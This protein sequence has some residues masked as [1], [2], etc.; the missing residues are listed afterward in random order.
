MSITEEEITAWGP[1]DYVPIDVRPEW[2]MVDIGPGRYP[3]PRADQYVDC[4]IA[5][6]ERLLEAGKNAMFSDLDEG[7]PEIADKEFDY[8]WASHVFEHAAP[9]QLEKWAA[10]LTRIAKRGTI[11][12]PSFAKE[13]LFHF[14]ELDHRWLVLP[15]A[16]AWEPPIFVEQNVGFL[17]RLRDQM[18]QKAT[19]FLYR[20]G[21]PHGCTTERY[22]RGW[23]QENEPN[24]DIVYH[25]EGELK[26]RILR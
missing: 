3:H 26:L 9:D 20:T 8:V 22:M 21:S 2:K 25:W 23:Y 10:T 19:C 5:N 14:E 1:R 6:V 17:N 18:M 13:S 24:L 11:V 16:N 4:D 12:M 15:S 7:L